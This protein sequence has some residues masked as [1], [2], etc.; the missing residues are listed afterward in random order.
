VIGFAFL[1]VM[2][3][4]GTFL[5]ARVPWLRRALVPASLIGGVVGLALVSADLSLGYTSQDFTAFTFHFFTLSF[6]SLCL[7]GSEAGGP[8]RPSVVPGG[9]WLSIIWVMSLVMQALVGLAVVTGY[10]LA[11]GKDLS[12]YLGMIVTHGFTQ[13]PGQALAFGAIWERQL[14]IT[15]AMSFGLIYASVGFVAAFAIGVPVARYAIRRGLN[16]NPS[17]R[18]DEAFVTGVMPRSANLSA[19]RQITHPGN[20]DT[21]AFHLGILGVA[22]VV[23][24]QYLQFMQ[25]LAA[26]VQ[27]FGVNLG[28]VF[29]HDLFFFHGLMVCVGLRF[30]LDRAGLGHFIDNE[31]QRRITGA[32]VDLMVVAT[33][34]SIEMALLSAF[35]VPILLVCLTVTASTVALCF[36][37]GRQLASLGP[38][39]A[40]TA[41]GCC[42]GSTGSGLLL[43]RMLDPDLSSGIGKEL[44]FFNIAILL[45]GFHVLMLMAPI[46]PS[47]GLGSVVVVYAATFLVGAVAL[48]VLARR[49]SAAVATVGAPE[50]GDPRSRG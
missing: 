18:L 43:L 23:T 28:L 22:Y 47:Y 46:L 3:L 8:G 2:I 29:S 38:E 24:D 16:A 4:I 14:G 34:M 49:L 33:L 44:A 39:R 12:A 17:A 13:G 37:F 31:T 50:P 40:L 30:L 19:G 6:M 26:S 11:A 10:N 21:L 35:I 41:F 1:A 36:G 7:T 9:T 45:L 27:F 20:V 42:C 15:H 48:L 5:R 25:P 32:S